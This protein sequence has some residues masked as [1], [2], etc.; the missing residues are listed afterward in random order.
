V[1]AL[2]EADAAS[3][4]DEVLRLEVKVI[5]YAPANE[6]IWQGRTS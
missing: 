6:V 2:S 1:P 3:W 5:V 4:V